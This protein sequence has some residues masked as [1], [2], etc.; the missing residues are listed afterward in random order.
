M[1]WNIIE[2]K[3][4]KI[5]EIFYHKK[6]FENLKEAISFLIKNN[7]VFIKNNSN[8]KIFALYNNTFWSFCPYYCYFY[9]IEEYKS[10]YIKEYN[11]INIYNE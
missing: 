9:S 3:K 6:R 1:S 2:F 8:K 4:N 7:I 10:D 11:I 5:K